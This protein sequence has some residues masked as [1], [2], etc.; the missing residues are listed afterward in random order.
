MGSVAR[1]AAAVFCSPPRRVAFAIIR[2]DRALVRLVAVADSQV[3]G[4]KSGD[5]HPEERNS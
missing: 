5:F 2:R 1:R 4:G 3:A